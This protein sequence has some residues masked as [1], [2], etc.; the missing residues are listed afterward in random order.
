MTPEKEQ[1]ISALAQLIT[2][3]IVSL[4]LK[5]SSRGHAATNAALTKTTLGEELR[6]LVQVAAPILIELLQKI[7]AQPPRPQDRSTAVAEQLTAP[8]QLPGGQ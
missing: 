8:Q 1:L 2:L 7:A 5:I 6:P 3:V 4:H